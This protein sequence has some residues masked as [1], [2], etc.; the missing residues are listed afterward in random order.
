LLLLLGA[1]DRYGIDS[2]LVEILLL[3]S[4]EC[5]GHSISRSCNLLLILMCCEEGPCYNI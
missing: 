5:D 1:F 4:P 2:S 3:H